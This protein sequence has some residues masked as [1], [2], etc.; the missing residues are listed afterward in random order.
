MQVLIWKIYKKI[1]NLI[2]L[3]FNKVIT[4]LLTSVTMVKCNCIP[5]KQDV[6]VVKSSKRLTKLKWIQTHESKLYDGIHAKKY[7]DQRERAEILLDKFLET[8][9]NKLCLMDGHGRFIFQILDLIYHT[10]KYKSLK[11]LK[12]FVCEIDSESH[13][14]HKK[15]F[16]KGVKLLK[17]D[18]FQIA[19]KYNDKKCIFYYNFCS[20]GKNHNYIIENLIREINKN[21][22]IMV[23]FCVRRAGYLY[24]F[25]ALLDS[26]CDYK[27]GRYNTFSWFIPRQNN[28]YIKLSD[29]I[30]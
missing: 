9:Y 19:N 26:I 7:K 8:R 1:E 18:I 4:K 24:N 15:T 20:F 12:I 2:V 5:N 17:F 22:L 6:T 21:H 3:M 10:K 16:P 11:N 23:T 28:Q 14:Y 27:T 30:E 29:Y 25:A 13:K